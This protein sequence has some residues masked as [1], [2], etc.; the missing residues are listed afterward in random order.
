MAVEVN[1]TTGGSGSVPMLTETLLSTGGSGPQ[2]K[3]NTGRWTQS[4]GDITEPDGSS[5][6]CRPGRV[7][8]EWSSFAGTPPM[9]PETSLRDDGAPVGIQDAEA[10]WADFGE[11]AAPTE[12]RRLSSAPCDAPTVHSPSALVTEFDPLVA[13]TKLV[14]PVDIHFTGSATSDGG[15]QT[16]SDWANFGEHGTGCSSGSDSCAPNMWDPVQ[17]TDNSVAGKDGH[18]C[19]PGDKRDWADFGGWRTHSASSDL[20]DTSTKDAGTWTTGVADMPGEVDWQAFPS[21]TSGPLSDFADFSSTGHSTSTPW[22]SVSSHHDANVEHAGN[23]ANQEAHPPFNQSDR[24]P[25]GVTATPGGTHTSMQDSGRIFSDC[26]AVSEC[27]ISA[28]PRTLSPS[29]SQRRPL[30]S[31][32]DQR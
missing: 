17:A 30:L 13:A 3:V 19:L 23:A 25:S 28:V 8:S 5:H 26:F 4:G 32:T 14:E 2:L 21:S 24:C 7:S 20:V 15:V 29:P 10:S 18:D 11:R 22:L 12:A 27:A 31:A 16:A 6:G 9:A 1:S